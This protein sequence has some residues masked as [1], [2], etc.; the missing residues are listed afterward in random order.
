[1]VPVDFDWNEVLVEDTGDF[2]VFEAFPLHNL[3][4]NVT[5]Q[6]LSPTDFTQFIIMVLLTWH[7]IFHCGK[8][9]LALLSISLSYICLFLKPAFF[10]SATYSDK[11]H[12]RY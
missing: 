4:N 6:V 8:L 11:L 12:T 1:M 3:S 10:V 7:P 2:F 9:S 5:L